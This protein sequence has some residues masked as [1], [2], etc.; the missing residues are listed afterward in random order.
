MRDRLSL[1]RDFL[2]YPA[3]PWP[4]KNHDR[5][6]EALAM[7][8]DRTGSVIPLVCSGAR[9][10]DFSRVSDRARELGLPVI[11]PGFVGPKELR[12]LYELATG[13][14]FPS[15]F[16]GWGLPV[17]EAFSAGLPVVSSSATGLPELVGDA[18]LIFDPESTE[19]IAEAVQ[20]VGPTRICEGRWPSEATI[21]T[22]CSAGTGLHDCSAPTTAGSAGQ[23]ALQRKTVSFWRL[24]LPPERR[25]PPTWTPDLR[26]R[27]QF[28]R[29]SARAAACSL[30]LRRALGTVNQ[31]VFRDR[32]GTSIS[33]PSGSVRL[34]SGGDPPRRRGSRLSRAGWRRSSTS[35]PRSVSCWSAAS[36]PP[37]GT[38]SPSRPGR[39]P[40]EHAPDR[41]SVWLGRPRDSERRARRAR[42]RPL[43]H[44]ARTRPARER[45][46]PSGDRA[47]PGRASPATAEPLR[48]RQVRLADPRRRG[49]PEASHPSTTSCPR[50]RPSWTWRRSG[51][52]GIDPRGSSSP[53][54][55]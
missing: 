26:T 48:V 31:V 37:P 10:A 38:T 47:E 43:R 6:L 44:R 4:H 30:A 7:I 1:P 17:C 24:R 35:S 49:P 13:L 39:T 12:G 28:P 14:A 8:R 15:R 34:R 25:L 2:L 54:T 5:L 23:I 46:R 16:E 32:C 3:K 42:D 9:A 33:R 22:S 19:Q 53:S 20:R 21:A 29:S 50:S 52:P 40:V 11:F 27:A 41:G 36:A 55:T 51:R 45:P 18:A